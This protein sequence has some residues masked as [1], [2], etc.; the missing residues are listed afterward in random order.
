MKPTIALLG[1]PAGGKSTLLEPYLNHAVQL[2]E[3]TKSLPAEDPRLQMCHQYW[4]AGKKF[5]TELVEALLETC[6]VPD[7]DWLIL[8]G[9]PRDSTQV[10]VMERHFDMR[11]YVLITLDDAVW[12]ERARKAVAERGERYDSTLDKLRSRKAEYELDLAQ[13]RE[14]VSFYEVDNSG[15]LPQVR[16]KLTEIIKKVLNT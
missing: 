14:V 3:Y 6:P 2:G 4:Q 10:P 7:E 8:D 16:I 9:S 11:G 1:P 13:M 5:S 12:E 15:D